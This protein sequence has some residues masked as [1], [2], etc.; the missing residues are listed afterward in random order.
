[1]KKLFA[2]VFCLFVCAAGWLAY[3]AYEFLH[4][5]LSTDSRALDIQV[6]PGETVR[7]IGAK[8]SASGL[9]DRPIWWEIYA[10]YT[11]KARSIKTGEYSLSTDLTPISLL[12]E[13]QL[14]KQKQYSFTILEGWNIWQLRDALAA[15]PVLVATLQDVEDKD[16]LASIGLAD[17]HP[18][19]QFLPD[20]YFFP[21][22]TTD[23]EFLLR[24]NRALVAKLDE[25]WLDRQDNLPVSSAYEALTL[26]SIIEKETSVASE[27]PIISGV[28]AG[29]LRKGMRL[30]M[31]PTVIYGIGRSFN[32]NITRRDL[33]T[34]TPY[35]TY[36]IAGLP[37]TP[38]AMAGAESLEA[39]VNPAATKALFF[40]A[41]GT[42]GHVFNE[43][44]EAHNKAVRKF[45]LKK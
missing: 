18:E 25:V 19:G 24:A 20:T 42:G 22:G 28:I 35:N 39:A 17:G 14:G 32:G 26:A 40:V 36:T 33:K 13:L 5:P 21:R 15:D 7:V 41:D 38:I 6:K 11:G 1:M 27:R 45:I 12:D 2:F 10:R 23:A 34:P 8:L 43:T 16:L 30:Q 44:V 3:D 37:P 9:L 31:D 4:A 29:R